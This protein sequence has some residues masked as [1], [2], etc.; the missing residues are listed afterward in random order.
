MTDVSINHLAIDPL[1]VARAALFR[2]AGQPP[3]RETHQRWK[4]PLAV[5]LP[6]TIV[7]SLGVWAGIGYAVKSLFF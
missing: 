3:L 5:T 6:I 4:I 1:P 2:D 7:V